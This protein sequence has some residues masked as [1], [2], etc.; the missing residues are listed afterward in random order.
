MYSETA[1]AAV[2][3]LEQH[4]ALGFIWVTG[5]LLSP[6]PQGACCHPLKLPCMELGLHFRG[7]KQGRLLAF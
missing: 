3:V 6:V 2:N 4:H 7:L 5:T 1:K